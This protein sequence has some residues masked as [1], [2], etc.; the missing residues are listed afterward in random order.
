MLV[1]GVSHWISRLHAVGLILDSRHLLFP[2]WISTG[3]C[4]SIGAAYLSPRTFNADTR[5]VS[6]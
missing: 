6:S 2:V 4:D 3:D 5:I 1:L